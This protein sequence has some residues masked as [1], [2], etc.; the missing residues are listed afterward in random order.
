LSCL[1]QVIIWLKLFKNTTPGMMNHLVKNLSQ[2]LVELGACL[3]FKIKTQTTKSDTTILGS[4][5]H[6]VKLG[7]A[8][9]EEQGGYI[10]L[11]TKH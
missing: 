4:M 7:V 10:H 8:V 6:L 2:A 9:V 11:I 1:V 5:V 3:N